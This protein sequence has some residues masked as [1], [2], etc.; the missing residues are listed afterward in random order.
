M[1]YAAYATFFDGLL[2][3]DRKLLEI[4]TFARLML[5]RVFLKDLAS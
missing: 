3:E 1:S 4:Y 2:A 5:T